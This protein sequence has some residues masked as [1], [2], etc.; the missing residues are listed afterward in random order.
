MYT[1]SV[2]DMEFVYNDDF[3]VHLSINDKTINLP[4]ITPQC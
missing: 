4:N 2:F 3:I 1:N